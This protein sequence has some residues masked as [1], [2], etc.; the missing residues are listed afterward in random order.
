[1]AKSYFKGDNNMLVAAGLALVAIALFVVYKQNPGWTE[2]S[3]G[4]LGF[5]RR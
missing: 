4:I 5:R 3:D 2:F 1:M